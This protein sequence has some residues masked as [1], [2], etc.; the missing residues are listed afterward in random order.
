M[1]S[2]DTDEDRDDDEGPQRKV[3]IVGR[4]QAVGVYE[5]T[6]EEW[7]ECVLRGEC[8]IP[9]GSLLQDEPN[10]VGDAL[11]WGRS[12]DGLAD[13]PV[14]Y[15]SWDDAQEYVAWLSRTTGKMYRLLSEAEWEYVARAG[16]SDVRLWN[17]SVDQCYHANGVDRSWDERILTKDLPPCND[18]ES[19]LARVGAY[20][21]NN[22]GLY[23]VIGNVHEWTL[24]C[25]HDNYEGAPEDGGAREAP[26]G[27]VCSAHPVRGGAWYNY[28]NAMRFAA[29][30]G[31][32]ATSRDNGIG[33]R[34]ALGH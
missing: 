14:I 31:F 7:F 21:P 30:E 32:T 16:S 23:D 28:P 27:E 19:G 29:R 1:G 33:L 15:V 25:W 24:D 11:R 34:V 18:N 6:F 20:R 13:R 9:Q 26:S 22:F 17:D 2:P 4:L 5:V 3:H 8:E 12:D 10:K